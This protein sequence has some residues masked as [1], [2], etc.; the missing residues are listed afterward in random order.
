MAVPCAIMEL[1]EGKKESALQRRRVH[2]TG[3]GEPLKQWKRETEGCRVSENGEGGDCSESHQ[4]LGRQL[5][6]G[7]YTLQF[8]LHSTDVTAFQCILTTL[9]HVYTAAYTIAHFHSPHAHASSRSPPTMPC[10][11]LVFFCRGNPME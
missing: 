10:I 8:D 4:R 3:K 1:L 6:S 7:I 5:H 2:A 9:I 11:H